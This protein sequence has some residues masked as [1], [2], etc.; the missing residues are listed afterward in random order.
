MDRKKI[1]TVWLCGC[2]GC[3]MSFLDL[4]EWL[5]DLLERVEITASPVT[6]IKEPPEVDIALIEGGISNEDNLRVLKLFRERAKILVALGDCA[7]FG[8][9]PMLRNFFDRQDVLDRAYVEAESTALGKE[10]DEEVP[11]L[12]DKVEPIHHFV[13][14][15]AFIPGCP[16]EASAIRT[17]LEE[18]VAGRLPAGKFELRYE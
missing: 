3:H 18:L 12:L 15:D 10:P 13:K 7:G 16:P 14:V 11:K 6:D 1:A 2:S 5:F 4:D 8:C 17:A 9:V